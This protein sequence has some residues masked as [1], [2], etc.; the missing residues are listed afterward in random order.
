ML[1]FKKY[2]IWLLA[3]LSG[4]LLGIS[5]PVNGFA[6]LIFVALVPILLVRTY[7]LQNP[8]LFSRGA[9]VLYSYVTFLVFNLFTTWWVAYSTIVGALLAFL[10]NSLFMALAFGLAHIVDSR[11]LKGRTSFFIL[12]FFF[13]SFEYLHMNWELTWS[14]LNLGNVFSENPNWVQWY[15]FT[16]VLGG[17]IWVIAINL[18]IQQAVLRWVNNDR[19]LQY[20]IIP[21]FITLVLIGIPIGYSFHLKNN[22]PKAEKSINALLIQPNI[23]PYDEA[24]ELTSSQLVDNILDLSKRY[25]DTNTQLIICPES[26]INRTM[27]E[28]SI[29]LYPAIEKLRNFIKE[30][31]NIDI[32]LGASTRRMLREGEE[33]KAYA[34]SFSNAPDKHYYNYNTALFIQNNKP[35][36]FYHKAKLVPGVERMPFAALL[37]PVEKYAIDLG[38][39]TGSLGVSTEPKL[40]SLNNDDY[41][42]P[43][44]CYESIYGEFVGRFSK[45]LPSFFAVIT[46]DAWWY[47]SPGHKQ[48][49]SYAR[50]RA[51]ESRRYVVR[52]ANTGISGVINAK[53]EVLKVSKFYDKTVIKATIPIYSTWTYYAKTGD[54]LGRISTFIAVLLV[55]MALSSFLRRKQGGKQS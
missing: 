36:E 29:E 26:S 45:G 44:I 17:S 1:Q 12:I 53:G 33:V 32:L 34:R 4:L 10:L 28:E 22:I 39:T 49:F 19:K 15:E 30:H 40:F 11:I 9:I 20:T 52:S 47:N 35:I 27:W 43:I 50:L 37:K 41:V 7:I 13:V 6:P 24:Y 2:Q 23:E 5:W 18:I 3:I 38:G 31:N 21:L 48:H 8:S 25:I 42:A 54:Y 55:F 14:W 16:G 51:I 46:N